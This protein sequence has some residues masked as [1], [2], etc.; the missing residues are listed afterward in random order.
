MGVQG[1]KGV[2]GLGEGCGSGGSWDQEGGR[3]RLEGSGRELRVQESRSWL[4]FWEGVEGSGVQKR[5][6]DLEGIGG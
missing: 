6:R 5:I 3:R 2:R 1:L 4:V